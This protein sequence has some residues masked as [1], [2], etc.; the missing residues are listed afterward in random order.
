MGGSGFSR[1][2]SRERKRA[3]SGHPWPRHSIAC[4]VKAVTLLQQ[5]R[6]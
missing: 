5:K 4:C 1:D 3:R 6:P 2:H